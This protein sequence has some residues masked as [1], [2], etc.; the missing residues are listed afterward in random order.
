MVF[1]FH[2]S[3]FSTVEPISK[4][5]SFLYVLETTAQCVRDKM[6]LEQCK[7]IIFYFIFLLTVNDVIK[8]AL[9]GRNMVVICSTVKKQAKRTSDTIV[10]ITFF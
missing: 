3:H 7:V 10:E 4:G 2:F 6:H 8:K 1:S 9:Y 5:L